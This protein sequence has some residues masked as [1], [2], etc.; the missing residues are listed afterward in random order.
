MKKA[1]DLST[2]QESTAVQDAIRTRYNLKAVPRLIVDWN[3]NRYTRP[4]AV[5]TPDDQDEG[6][7]IEHFPIESIVEPIRPTKGVIKARVNEAVASKGYIYAKTPKFYVSSID[8]VYKYWTSPEPTDG[9]GQFR[10]HSD[11]VTIARPKVVYRIGEVDANGDPV[12]V[13]GKQSK[14]GTAVPSNKIVVKFENTWATPDVFRVYIKNSHGGAWKQVGGTSPAIA[15]DGTMTLVYNGTGWTSTATPDDTKTENIAAIELQVDSLRAGIRRNGNVLTYT[16]RGSDVQI[17]TDGT[18][19]SLNV[20]SI[21]AHLEADLT[22]RLIDV[23][24]TFDMSEKS[25]LYPIGTITT[26]TASLTL[27]NEDGIFNPENTSSPFYNLIEPNARVTMDY[28]YYLDDTDEPTHRVPQ[29]DMYIAGWAN[30][31]GTTTVELEDYSKFLKETKPRPFMVEGKTSTEIIWRVLDSVGFVDYEID[32]SDR[33]TEHVVPVFWVTGDMTVWEVLDDLAKATQTAIYFDSNGKLQVRTRGAAFRDEGIDWNLLGVD[34]GTNLS[35]IISWNPSGESEANKI[36]VGYKT[37]KWKVNSQGKPAM[38]KVWEPDS[39]T[40][41]VRSSPLR[42]TIDNNSKF[43]FL[44]QK[45]IRLWPYKSKVQIDGEIIQ[46]DGKQYAYYTYTEN[47]ASNGVVTYSNPQRNTK[48]VHDHAE[49]RK[50]NRETPPKFRYKNHYTGGLW[51]TERGLWFSTERNHT[52]EANR[53]NTHMELRGKGVATGVK[54]PRGFRFNRHHSTVTINTPNRM[55]D[56]NDTFWA[57]KRTAGENGYRA[58]GTRF[59][60]NK[61]KASTTQTA[62][63]CFQLNQGRENGYYVEVKLSKTRTAKKR[64][65]TN[66]VSI[67]SRVDGKNIVLDRGKATAI[68][69]NIWYDLDVYH[70]GT[71][72][73]QRIS[74]WINGQKIAQSGVNSTTAQPDGGRFGFFAKGRTNISFEYIYALDQG[75]RE[76]LEDYGFYDLKY[77]GIRGGNWEREVVWETRTRRRRIRKKKWR[78]EDYKKNMYLFDEF[79]PYVHEVREFDVDFDP[80]PVRYSYL[81]S[82]NEWYSAQ[83]E[84]L[85]SPFGARFTVANVSRNHAVLH[86][87]DRLTYAGASS[88]INQV[89]VVLGQNLE[90][91]DEE[92]VTRVSEKSIRA[93]GE[94]VSELSSD[95]IQSRG[96]ARELAN[97]MRHHWADSVDEVSVEVFGNPLIEIGDVV[98]VDYPDENATPA[99]HQYFVVGTS[100]SFDTGLTTTLQLR[101][102]RPSFE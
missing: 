98:D 5:N 15:D 87:E 4:D 32:E 52:V 8:D 94:I 18:N 92:T 47:V 60:F 24:D 16:E 81:F 74:V 50:L 17:P 84:Y 97:W 96:M 42:R 33:V 44:S 62:G 95:W 99:T 75:D 69:E 35:D 93:R 70:S 6:F 7:D 1:I 54:D 31:E 102:R 67:I 38:S 88:G 66:E 56:Y 28:M 34:S 59:R 30:S 25:Q 11:G 61:D 23:T 51:I 49:A 48:I 13:E 22:D 19:S 63:L 77:G 91:A 40:V 85:G 37:T 46:Y 100:N 29:L 53:W 43:I 36:N 64:K 9:T 55:K 65:I 20:I 27:A 82:T 14:V 71:G 26:N 90:I 76:P 73:N 83:V 78:K 57:F 21:E 10:L 68:G 101:R 3:W 86:G 72:N 45:E 58:Y 79:G 80:A 12:F 2:G 89:F 39:E 41:T